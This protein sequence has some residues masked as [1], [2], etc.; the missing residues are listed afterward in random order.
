MTGKSITPPTSQVKKGR[1]G[2]KDGEGGILMLE[3]VTDIY[4]HVHAL[5]YMGNTCPQQAFPQ[6]PTVQ[7]SAHLPWKFKRYRQRML[8][9]P[10]YTSQCWFHVISKQRSH[11]LFYLLFS[12]IFLYLDATKH[13]LRALLKLFWQRIWASRNKASTFCFF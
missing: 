9:K 1:E 8:I 11:H 5:Y 6:T 12:C 4:T 3:F 7:P 2:C 13:F 10:L